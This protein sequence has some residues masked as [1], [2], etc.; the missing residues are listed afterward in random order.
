MPCLAKTSWWAIFDSAFGA[1]LKWAK[2]WTKKYCL[3]NKV[4]TVFCS[5]QRWMLQEFQDQE[6]QWDLTGGREDG[7]ARH[8]ELSPEQSVPS[9]KYYQWTGC[10]MFTLP[11]LALL[12]CNIMSSYSKIYTQI[13]N[14]TAW[15]E[16]VSGKQIKTCAS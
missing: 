6:K 13:F 4:R 14:P 2:N 5:S 15:C 10:P 3:H 12:C 1:C 16:C 9:G 8:Q 7:P 11:L